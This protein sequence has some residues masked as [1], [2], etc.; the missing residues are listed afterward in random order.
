MGN[1]FVLDNGSLGESLVHELSQLLVR[2]LE[3]PSGSWRMS[4]PLPTET[5]GYDVEGPFAARSGGTKF[6]YS[7]PDL[8]PFKRSVCPPYQKPWTSVLVG[9]CSSAAVREQKTW[10]TERLGWSADVQICS[11]GNTPFSVV[12]TASCPK[13]A[14]NLLFRF[15]LF[16]P[17][18]FFVSQ[19][20]DK[21]LTTFL[22]YLFSRL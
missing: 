22:S 5:L 11:S 20:S 4:Y 10:Q 6:S 16:R 3:E 15:A 21:S 2:F 8:H 9:V 17:S 13:R 12:S 7:I 14:L 1:I 19:G 18:W